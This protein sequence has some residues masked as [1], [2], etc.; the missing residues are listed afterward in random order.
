MRRS[1]RV[2]FLVTALVGV[3][4]EI[5]WADGKLPAII[6]SHMVLQRVPSLRDHRNLY[7]IDFGSYF[8]KP[9]QVQPEGGPFKA[10][11]IHRFVRLLADSGTDTFVIN[12]NS[13]VPWYPS[14]VTPT[15][16]TGYVR[17]DPEGK[18]AGGYG[19]EM[20]NLLLDLQESD[21]DWLAESIKACRACG[22]SPWVSVRMNDPHGQAP[23][24]E[25]PLHKDPKYLL[26]QQGEPRIWAKL[27]Y[28]YKEVRDY[29]FAI[30][31]E[32]VEDYDFDG[33]ELDWKRSAVCIPPP[34]AQEQ[35]DMMTAWFT[36]IR[37]LTQAKAKRTGRPYYLGMHVPSEY[38]KL[39]HIG[40]DVEVIAKAGLIDF[41]CPTNFM[42]TA[43]DMPYDRIKAELGPDLT[44]YGVTEL[45]I[46][47]E[48]RSVCDNP[49]ALRGNAAGK[50]V[51]GA[52]GIEQYNFFW[53]AD[54]AKAH[55][56]MR[57][58]HDLESLR[59]QTKHY[60][61][62]RMGN[63]C[64]NN[65]DRPVPLPATLEPGRRRTFRLPMCAEP[66]DRGL[67]LT[68]QVAVQKTSDPPRIG[69]SFN[70]RWPNY[71]GQAT[72]WLL[73]PSK[74]KRHV[75]EQQAYDYRFGVNEIIEGW[76]EIT[77]TN[78]GGQPAKI[79]GLEL[80]VQ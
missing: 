56:A 80:G 3:Q 48:G 28:Q 62:S 31:R 26:R 22:I 71:D 30:I 49:P 10:A 51:L 65:F 44:I 11:S 64:D 27:N 24:M 46:K 12:P 19:P 15:I 33:L 66:T 55:P 54:Y 2:M 4:G 6:G 73:F 37:K 45:Q 39:R 72:D 8:W 35:I 70:G 20:L 34:A 53:A 1:A 60:A 58:L 13:K 77:L 23:H 50:L 42:Q 57:N 14:K 18:T 9:D 74:P 7:N 38:K 68:I 17:D 16:L 21:V 32:L 43:W 78:S 61:L 47:A 40:I 69:V 52:D 79:A 76:N 67:E 36:E 41:L 59:G 63:M 25:S 29:Y 5:V 75:S